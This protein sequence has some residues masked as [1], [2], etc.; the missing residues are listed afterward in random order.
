MVS[1]QIP[2]GRVEP[3]QSEGLSRDHGVH[4]VT[5]Q[6]SVQQRFRVISALFV[7]LNRIR[8]GSVALQTVCDFSQSHAFSRARIKNPH[9]SR[10][11]RQQCLQSAFQCQFVSRVVAIACKITGKP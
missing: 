8:L 11:R 7:V 3:E 4:Q 10:G 9:P 6:H 5:L 2:V 1:D